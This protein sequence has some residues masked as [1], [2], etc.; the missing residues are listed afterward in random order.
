[1]VRIAVV[2]SGIAGLCTAWRLATLDSGVAVTLYEG[3]PRFGGHANT[4]ELE[5]DGITCGVDTGFLV[6]NERTYPG[7]VRL[8]EG[9]GVATAPS[10]M[11]F[12]VQA[13]GLEWCG[14]S[15]AAVFCQSRN[16]VRKR[17]WN[18]LGDILRF[19]RLCSALAEGAEPIPIDLGLEEFLDH[20]DFGNGFRED[21]LLPMIGSIW[22]SPTGAMS[23]FPVATL[24]RFCHNHGLLQIRD[25]PQWR[26]VA[27]GSR[28]YVRRMLDRIPD[29]RAGT[30]VHG[31]ERCGSSVVVHTDRAGERFDGAVLACH[32]DESLALLGSEAT[33]QERA[34][35][36]ALRY[37]RNRAV[38]HTDASVLP[39]RK[40][41]W[42]SW[43]YERRQAEGRD[44][45]CLHYLLNRL[46]PL[47]WQRPVIVSM[48]PVRPIDPGQVHAQFDYEH[49]VFDIDAI[50]AQSRID[51]LQGNGRI[52]YC[53]AW[54][55]YGF[56][57]DGLRAGFDVAAQIERALPGMRLGAA[58]LAHA[59]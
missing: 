28:Q 6:F 21:Y 10:D 49:P 45:I 53:G 32:A 18:M 27:G 34:V 52:W 33:L 2:G 35:L 19:N 55:G 13:P 36:G 31:V 4:Y 47:P 58:D 59:A 1:M 9:L 17:F 25:R 30:A 26:T 29:A 54:C 16:L 43:N 48:N 42:A 37:Q 44:R 22:S 23:A 15:I 56:H 40:R 46:Q 51:S 7:L 24:I 20:H 14:S 12:S 5:L 39:V 38:L 50:A 3:Q 57:E 8:F 41:A 11:S